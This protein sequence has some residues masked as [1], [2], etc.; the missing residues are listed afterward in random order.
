MKMY[1]KK[2]RGTRDS[3]TA[4]P[5]RPRGRLPLLQGLYD[6]LLEYLRVTRV[7]G[8]VVNIHVVCATTEALIKSNPSLAQ[9]LQIPQSY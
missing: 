6:K 8:G 9:H 2:V 4:L 3:V 1:L 5:V 7:K